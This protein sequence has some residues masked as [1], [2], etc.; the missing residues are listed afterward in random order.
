MSTVNAVSSASQATQMMALQQTRTARDADGDN[1]GSRAGEVEAP[2][3]PQ[4]SRTVGTIVN[5]TA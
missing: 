4:A 5:T 3:T 1:D 2:K